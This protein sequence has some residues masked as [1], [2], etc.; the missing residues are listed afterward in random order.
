MPRPNPPKKRPRR[1]PTG[2]Q[3]AARADAALTRQTAQSTQPRSP[4]SS[5]R[6]SNAGAAAAAPAPEE[7]WSR[8]SYAI[9]IALMALIQLPVTAIQWALAPAV[10]NGISK[11]PVYAAVA[12][13]NPVS[14][15]VASLFAAPAAKY[16]S[17]EKRT[18]RF[19]ETI[20]A[21][22]VTYFVWLV[23][24]VGAGTLLTAGSP[25]TGG[26][27]SSC[28]TASAVATP[29]PAS[30]SAAPGT[31]CPSAS[32]QPSASPSVS[33]SASPSAS[34]AANA[35]T[36]TTSSPVVYSTFS[37]IDIIAFVATLYFY[38]PLYRRLRVR[39]PPPPRRDK[40]K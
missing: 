24:A 31:P 40:K 15:L 13:L 2:G 32:P 16:L 6:T 12:V 37:L 34:A 38:P 4:A 21:P 35:T 36:I 10:S 26:A 28:G 22:I 8:R 23:L 9:L 30:A 33:A 20:F 7:M 14:L 19:M 39:R 3:D 27:P 25:T 29:L 11:G 1:R 18:L 5:S 17:G